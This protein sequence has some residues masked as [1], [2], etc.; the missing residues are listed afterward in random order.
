MNRAMA[1]AKR[2]GFIDDYGIVGRANHL[3]G[4]GLLNMNYSSAGKVFIEDKTGEGWFRGTPE[5]AR[6]RG[7][8]VVS[9][10][11]CHKPAV[12]LDH[13]YPWQTEY[14]ACEDHLKEYDKRCGRV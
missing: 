7:L 13:S 11:Y 12:T 14:T 1:K 2:D 6:K 3:P 5:E 8:K 10:H 4:I 9:C